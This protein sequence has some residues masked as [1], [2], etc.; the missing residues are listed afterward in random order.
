MEASLPYCWVAGGHS[1]HATAY[2]GNLDDAGRSSNLGGGG[3]FGDDAGD[4]NQRLWQAP[5]RLS[6]ARGGGLISGRFCANLVGVAG[7]EPATPSSRTSGPY[8]K[9]LKVIAWS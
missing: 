4:T 3:G 6:E 7:F 1:S 9:S 8:P 5:S 2:A